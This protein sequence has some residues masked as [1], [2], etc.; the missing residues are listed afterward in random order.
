MTG[1]DDTPAKPLPEPLR[2][3]VTPW[4]EARAARLGTLL[5]GALMAGETAVELD[6]RRVPVEM[7]IAMTEQAI[8]MVESLEG[9]PHA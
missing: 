8:S 7:L 4:W 6:G 3:L 9:Q 2:R 5:E 1:A